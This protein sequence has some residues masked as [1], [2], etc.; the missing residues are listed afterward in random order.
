MT[1]AIKNISGDR[2]LSSVWSTAIRPLV[3]YNDD[4]VAQSTDTSDVDVNDLQ[5]GEKPCALYLIAPSPMELERLHPAY[6]VILDVAL[7]RLMEHKVRRWRHRLLVLCDEL[8][9]YG[10][11]RAIEKGI[12]V[13]AGYGLKGLLVV[14]DLEAL[15]DVYGEHSQIWGNCRVRVFMGADHDLTAKRISE[16][17]LGMRTQAHEMPQQSPVLG[18]RRS[19]TVQSHARALLTTDELMALPD[20]QEVVQVVGMHPILAYKCDYRK[21]RNLRVRV[22]EGT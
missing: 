17:L 20:D 10:Y 18:Q 13:M 3:L 22:G 7:T 5:Y 8:P 16:N 2:E 12:P 6:R 14:Q 11:T 4:L 9:A 15:W 21:D 1:R 19:I